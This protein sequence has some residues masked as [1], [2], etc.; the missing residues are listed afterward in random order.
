MQLAVPHPRNLPADVGRIHTMRPSPDFF[1]AGRVDGA[2]D[3][4][5][6]AHSHKLPPGR[7]AKEPV[8]SLTPS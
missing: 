3:I 4:V 2:M 6:V 8:N 7:D 1:Q 5:L